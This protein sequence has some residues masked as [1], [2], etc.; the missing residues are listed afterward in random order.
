MEQKRSLTKEEEIKIYQK[1][2]Y[3]FLP[4][5]MYVVMLLSAKEDKV[6]KEYLNEVSNAEYLNEIINKE[7][8]GIAK[9][10]AE[11]LNEKERKEF[12]GICEKVR[13]IAKK[14]KEKEVEK[15]DLKEVNRLLNELFKF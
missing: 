5:K 12:L 4:L 15:K 9:V 10:I 14:I 2:F 7:Y 8:K 3:Y 13:G 11:G 6:F 1:F